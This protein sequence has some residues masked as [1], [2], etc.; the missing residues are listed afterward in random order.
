MTGPEPGL[1]E[2]QDAITGL[3][4]EE[5]IGTLATVDADGCPSASAMHI[6]GD[7]LAVYV[8]TFTYNRKY[9]EMLADPRVSYAVS[10]LPPGGFDDRFATRSL[11]VKGRATLLTTDAEIQRAV[12][13]SREQFPWLAQTAMYDHVKLPDQGQQVFFRIDPVSAVWGRPQGAPAVAR[14]PGV[15]RRGHPDHRETPVRR[16]GRPPVIASCAAQP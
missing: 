10:Y 12:T 8:H 6:A 9:A 4:R 15:R 1:T 16:R 14:V 13:V 5:E 7:G 3:L 2:I 11:Q